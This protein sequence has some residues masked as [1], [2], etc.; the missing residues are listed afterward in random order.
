MKTLLL[1]LEWTGNMYQCMAGVT[2]PTVEV[3]VEVSVEVT[4]KVTVGCTCTH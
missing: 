2:V 3:T 4:V 1:I